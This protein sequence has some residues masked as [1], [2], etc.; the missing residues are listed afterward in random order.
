MARLINPPVGAEHRVGVVNLQGDVASTAEHISHR[1][2]IVV[3]GLEAAQVDLG[4]Q[5]AVDPDGGARQ[6]P[7]TTNR[8]GVPV[9]PASRRRGFRHGVRDVTEAAAVG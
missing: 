6:F 5:Q 3:V 8:E 2:G 4:D 1:V 9:S 7:D